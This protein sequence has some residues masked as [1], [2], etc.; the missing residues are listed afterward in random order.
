[1]PFK[2]PA[3]VRA[4]SKRHYDK[5]PEYYRNRNRVQR[6]RKTQFIQETKSVPC[7]DCGV[8]HPPYVMEFDHVG[9]DKLYCVTS[10]ASESWS[11]LKAEIAK[12]EIV[13]ANCHAVR[14]YERRNGPVSQMAEDS[15]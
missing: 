9:D 6:E 11:R 8:Q 4:A 13:C 12:C 10:M 5:N 3:K 14:T 7:A 15:G 2:D 1:M